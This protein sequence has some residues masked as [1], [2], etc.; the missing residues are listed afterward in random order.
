[1]TKY[2]LPPI[3]PDPLYVDMLKQPHL[4]ISGT[5]GSGKSVVINGLIKNILTLYT[6]YNASMVLIDPKQVELPYDECPH[7]VRHSIAEADTLS[8][9][10][11]VNNVMD[12]RYSFLREHRVKKCPNSNIYIFIDEYADICNNRDIVAIIQ[13]IAALGRAAG[14]HLIIATQRCTRDIV[15]GLIKTNIDSRLC[16][17][18]PTAQDSRNLINRSGAELLPRYG[19]G[20]YLTPDTMIPIET[21]IPYVNDDY[22]TALYDFW[23]KQNN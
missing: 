7:T 2:I 19:K 15:N 12:G 21:D 22:M 13:R 5:T 20:L 11:W 3:K 10:E 23:R 8:A 17:R 1:M 16:L 4:L 18:V 14:I 9:L 6:P